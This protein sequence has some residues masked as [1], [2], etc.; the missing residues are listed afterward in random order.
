MIDRHVRRQRHHLRLPR[1]HR[2]PNN[3]AELHRSCR[4][5]RG[6][7]RARRRR[8]AD[9][10]SCFSSI[11]ELGGAL[12]EQLPDLRRARRSDH[13]LDAGDKLE[14]LRRRRVHAV[15]LAVGAAAFEPRLPQRLAQF[16]LLLAP[17]PLDGA[18]PAELALV[19]GANAI[20]KLAALGAVDVDAGG[21]P[22][23]QRA[24]QQCATRRGHRC[25]PRRGAPPPPP[26]AGS[27]SVRLECAS[28]RGRR[29]A[30][31]A[32]SCRAR[33]RRSACRGGCTPAGGRGAP[34]A[35]TAAG[36]TA[37]PTAAPPERRAATRPLAAAA[38]GRWDRHPRPRVNTSA[39]RGKRRQRA[40]VARVVVGSGRP[41]L[42]RAGRGA[43]WRMILPSTT[44]IAV[45][46]VQ[47]VAPSTGAG[48]P[49]AAVQ[50]TTRSRN[51]R[52]LHS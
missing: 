48:D 50:R 2:M 49:A 28:R 27:R 12:G 47:R 13:R 24:R 35:A 23:A 22:F 7:N 36:S 8:S 38:A 14:A 37:A 51:G 26:R 43:R 19:P 33:A 5:W 4:A 46:S 29:R 31:A 9:G 45:A 18:Q 41:A 39:A 17:L 21:R 6:G 30:R 20:E 10:I 1:R 34:C 32:R 42:S 25:P 3:C 15:V 11:G 16:L 52:R 40:A 44:L